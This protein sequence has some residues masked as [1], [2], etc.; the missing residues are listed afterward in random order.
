[1]SRLLP[2]RARARAILVLSL[3]ILLAVSSL[4]RAQIVVCGDKVVC[5]NPLGA[6]V[7]HPSSA[8]QC[9]EIDV[10]ITS[11]NGHEWIYAQ[12]NPGLAA[13]RTFTERCGYGAGPCVSDAGGGTSSDWNPS[14]GYRGPLHVRYL[15]A[16]GGAAAIEFWLKYMGPSYTSHHYNTYNTR[17]VM[18]VTDAGRSAYLNLE[19]GDWR[20]PAVIPADGASTIP[21]TAKLMD[22]SCRAKVDFVDLRTTLGTLLADGQSGKSIRVRTKSDGTVSATLKADTTPGIADVSA[23]ASGQLATAQ[24]WM[25]GLVLSAPAELPANGTSSGLVTAALDCNGTPP[26]LDDYLRNKITIG[27]STSAGSLVLPGGKPAASVSGHPGPLG[28][29]T[30]SLQSTTEPQTA[31][32]RATSGGVE[33]F[34]TTEFTGP[35]VRL[36]ATRTEYLSVPGA[37]GQQGTTGSLPLGSQTPYRDAVE[38]TRYGVSTIEVTA[39]VTGT[40]P[41]S[42]KQILLT[43]VQRDAVGSS[44]IEFPPSVT[45]GADGTVKF[46]LKTT[47]LYRA[48]IALPHIVIKGTLAEDSSVFHELDVKTVDNFAEVLG[49]YNRSMGTGAVH[50]KAVQDAI[51]LMSP[52]DEAL[53]LGMY[54]GLRSDLLASQAY[55]AAY[56]AITSRQDE[57]LAGTSPWWQHRVL[58]FL[59]NL[60][61]TSYSSSVGSGDERWL[62]N[63]LHY[64]PLFVE[65]DS[66]LAVVLYPQAESW[67]GTHA[68]VL[69]PWLEQQGFYYGYAEWKSILADPQLTRAGSGVDVQPHEF[70][71]GTFGGTNGPSQHYPNNGEPYYADVDAVP[72][73]Y[74]PTAKPSFADYFE[75]L[76]T[77]FVEC[78][79]FATLEDAQGRRSGYAPAPAS[80][81]TVDEIPAL[82]R[83]TLAGPDGTL[84][85]RFGIPDT[86][87]TPLTL[88]LRAY[89][90]GPMTISIVR[91][92]Q[93]RRWVYRD[94]TVA[95]GDVATLQFAPAATMPPP[96]QFAGGRTVQGAIEPIGDPGASPGDVVV[97]GGTP[98]RVAGIVFANGDLLQQ[99]ATVRIGGRDATSVS[100]LNGSTLTATVPAGA[101]EGDADIVVTNPGGAQATLTGGLSYY[102]ARHYFAEGASTDLFDVRF[103]LL[104]PSAVDASATFSFQDRLGHVYQHTAA[105][106]SMRRV[107]VEP[108]VLLPAGGHEFSTMVEAT[109]HL[110][111]D[112]TMTWDARGYGAHTE[113]SVAAPAPTWYLAEG[114]THSGFDLFF[115]IQNVEARPV[116]VAVTYLRPAPLPPVERTYL[117][118]AGERRTIWV[119]V[120]DPGLAATDVA[121]AFEADG[122]VVVERAMYR[123]AP[124]RPYLAG[125][126]SRGADGPATRWWFAEGATGTFF[127]TFL[128]LANPGTDEARLRVR[129]H[130]WNGETVERPLRVAGRSRANLWVDVEDPA[131]GATEFGIEVESENGVPVVAERA[132]W[133]PGPTPADW[134]EAH[135]TS[136]A[137]TLARRW[138]TADGEVAGAR[139]ASTYLLLLN[140]SDQSTEARVTLVLDN[141]GTVERVAALPARSRTTVDVAAWF[142]EA[143]GHRFAAEV[144]VPAGAPGEGIVVERAT[145]W[146]STAGRWLA[147][148]ALRATSW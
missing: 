37:T 44:F 13:L 8:R 105:V 20:T 125:H 141:G 66:H 19:V 48:S 78:P 36:T 51:A 54:P 136:G 59:N 69:D 16:S 118:G 90:S 40:T 46:K 83:T 146:D 71:P 7:N 3:G 95:A 87:A 15:V 17:T 80:Q 82:V 39:T 24:A 99:G 49:R 96:L 98:V 14:I 132:M 84:R 139:N 89:G 22:T 143:A 63:G 60:Q 76:D 122:G 81:P 25:Y 88:R 134:A 92:R 145:Y 123:S 142:P 55:G 129:Y 11:G 35:K 30:A 121:T 127:D 5:D 52:S 34:A 58:Q 23:A 6:T 12:T 120:E 29:L 4:A 117:V 93:G 50:D 62:L 102:L 85:W 112:R 57:L 61:W 103:A 31:N 115:L 41:A 91:A 75:F 65:G 110:V 77:V 2:A 130:L 97:G 135:A 67:Q 56:P 9:S 68:R 43:S 86:A 133:W 26:P 128:L 138:I 94:V 28:T 111:A 109:Q 72:A 114:A 53:L 73:P 1:M 47:D 106:P 74:D 70:T 137:T 148:V 33:A 140:P 21:V 113:T 124:G 38:P 18:T 27:I 64:G 116:N 10:V 107:T 144:S 108:K 79:V 126:A 131:L 45:T 42:G 32:L 119:D 101:A 147:G 104:N 100:V